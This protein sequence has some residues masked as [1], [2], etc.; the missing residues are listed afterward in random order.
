MIAALRKIETDLD[1][2]ATDAA[3]HPVDAFD[4]RIQARRIGAQTEIL[5][6]GLEE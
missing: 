4:I 5:E 3:D 1:K 6:R 2:L